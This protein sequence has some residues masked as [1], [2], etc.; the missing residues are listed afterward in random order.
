MGIACQL[1]QVPI[2]IG[3]MGSE[4]FGLWMTLSS[5]SYMITFADFGM[6]VGVQNRLAEAFAVKQLDAARQLF[7][8]AFLFLLC[9]A[10]VLAAV[11]LPLAWLLN[12]PVIFGLTDHSIK[13][14]AP[15]AVAAIL[16]TFCV[17]FPFGLA[18]RLAYSQQLGWKHNVSQACGNVVAVAALYLA[19]RLHF[20]I[21]AMILCA[22]APAVLANVCLIVH[23]LKRLDWLHLR[24]FR[25]DFATVRELLGLGMY[26]TVQQILNLS[27]FA[28]PQIVISTSLGAA[29]VTPFNLAQRFFNLF[30]VLQNAFMLPLWPAYSQA[31][32]TG[33]FQWI[34]ATLQRSLLATTFLTI[35]PMALGAF[36]AKP[37]ILLWVKSAA[38]VPSTTLIWLMFLW[39][40]SVFLQQPFGFLLAG[41]S[42]V[43]RMTY[44][45]VLAAVCSAGLMVLLVRWYA[46]DGVLL[47]MLIGSVPIT[48]VCNVMETV[49][50]LRTVGHPSPVTKPEKTA[51]VSPEP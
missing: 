46:Q 9:V 19:S 28:L 44:Y 18:Q 6:G 38:A 45:S 15:Q 16:A 13:A 4:A 49:L 29:A 42:R 2:A 17:G 41:V 26:F 39:N 27:L 10:T 7:G 3:A 11:L 24:G 14:E 8:S 51:L 50:Y 37:I 31:K 35:L 5:I 33:E 36:L 1:L 12:L 40:A 25:P 30:G 22:A 20:G 34:R 21:G 48:F 43:Q 23:L 47:G 32:A